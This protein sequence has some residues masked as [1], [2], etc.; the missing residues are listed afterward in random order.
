MAS[1]PDN[2]AV[3]RLAIEGDMTI[4]R[5]AEL[6]EAILAAQA[7]AP[8]LEIDLAG[9]DDL[10]SAGLQLLVMAKRSAAAD[11]RTLRLLGHSR[12]V[13]DVFELLDMGAYFGDAVVI[14]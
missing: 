6:R 1:P 10:D 7:S 3:A 14:A 11:G 13:L 12:A 5:A 4:Y 2:G 9:V 8:A